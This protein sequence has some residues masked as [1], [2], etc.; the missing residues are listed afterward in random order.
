MDMRKGIGSLA[1]LIKD[2]S[3]LEPYNYFIFWFLD[4]A[5]TTINICILMELAFPCYI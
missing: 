5:K 3:K 2:T 1:M 4:E